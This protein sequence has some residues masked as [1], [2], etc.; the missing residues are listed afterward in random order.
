[1]SPVSNNGRLGTSGTGDLREE[2]AQRRADLADTVEALASRA[3]VKARTRAQVATV[4]SRVRHGL[5]H[6]AARTRRSLR[7]HPAPWAV[8]AAAATTL[9]LALVVLPRRWR[10]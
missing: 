8:S 2:I 5:R 3:D 10:R 7:E 6:G 4:K 1:M 9:A